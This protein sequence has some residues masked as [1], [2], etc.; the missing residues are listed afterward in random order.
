MD[1]IGKPIG[2]R[3]LYGE[4]DCTQ[5]LDL[6]IFFYSAAIGSYEAG[7]VASGNAN[8]SLGNFS[9]M[10]AVECMQIIA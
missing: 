1:D 8:A 5:W 6:A 9:E 4:S 10:A 2:E 3:K 7:D